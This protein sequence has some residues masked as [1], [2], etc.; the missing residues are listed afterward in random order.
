M[1]ARAAAE[2]A[3]CPGAEGHVGLSPHAPYTTT[4]ELLKAS[5]AQA[6]TRGWR[7]T[8]HVAESDEEFDMFSHASGPLYQWLQSQRDMRDCGNITPVQHLE[9]LGYL[10]PDLLAVHVNHLGP[11]DALTLSNAGVHVV[12]CPRSHAYFGHCAF[13]LETLTTHNVNI[14]LGTDSLVTVRN[15]QSGAPRLNLFLEMGAFSRRFPDI[16]PEEVLRMITLNAATALGRRGSLGEFRQ[17][18]TA[19]LIAIPFA[20]AVSDAYEAT[21]HHDSPVTASMI[22]GQWAIAPGSTASQ[23]TTVCEAGG[24]QQ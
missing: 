21:V 5:A 18:A 3:A 11:I 17:N 22:R 2:L 15:P 10:G 19:D 13:P 12:H 23:S 8:T 1:A 7:L 20:G 16:A 6:R 9:K 24:L 4:E 14:C